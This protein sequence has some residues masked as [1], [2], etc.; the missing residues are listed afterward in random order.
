[1]LKVNFAQTVG[2]ALLFSPE[3][4]AR[5]ERFFRISIFTY[6]IHRFLKGTSRTHRKKRAQAQCFVFRGLRNALELSNVFNGASGF[7]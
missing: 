3:I 4:V 7:L 6:E 5:F 2:A 1:M